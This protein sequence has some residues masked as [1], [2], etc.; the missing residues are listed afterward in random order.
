MLALTVALAAGSLAGC[1]RAVQ[2][3][4]GPY[5]PDPRCGEILLALRGDRF[6]LREV[7]VT[8]QS[9]MAWGT[10]EAAIVLR[11]GVEPPGPTTDRCIGVQSGDG[12]QVDWI[13][14]EADSPLIPSHA[15]REFGN[16]TFI[17]YGRVPAVEIMVPARLQLEPADVLQGVARAVSR[18]PADRHCVGATE[19]TG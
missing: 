9:T 6:G 10:S 2:L 12:T 18:A 4:P 16:W 13:N 5:A 17:T 8:A 3:E 11:C 19:I 14:P 7:P 1:A 15:D